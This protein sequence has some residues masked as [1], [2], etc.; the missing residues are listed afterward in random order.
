M[1]EVIDL[2]LVNPGTKRLIYQSLG[3]EVAAVEPPFWIAAIASSLRA[4]NFNVAIIDANA[5]N[6]SADETA[7]RIAQVRPRLVAVFVYGSQPSASTQNMTAAI[8]ICRRIKSI[9]DV[10]VGCGGLHPTALPERSLQETTADFIIEG[11]GG[12]TLAALIT[13]LKS[14]MNDYTAIPGLWYCEKG[15][16]QHTFTPDPSD[17]V[18]DVLPVAAWDLLPMHLYRAHN[19]HCFDDLNHRSPYAAIYTSLGCPF[20]CM[21]CCINALFGKPS[22]RYRSPRIVLDELQL[23]ATSYGV[24]NIKIIDE[25]F[26]LSEKHYLPII[27]GIIQRGLTFNI[28]AYARVDTVQPAHLPLLKKAGVNWLALGIESADASVRNGARKQMRVDDIAAVIDQIH[29]A[30]IHVIGNYIF[31]LPDDTVE[32]MQQTLDLAKRL[33]CEFANFYT[34]MAYPGSQLYQVALQ[35]NWALPPSWAAYSQHGYETL[36]LPTKHLTAAQVLAFRDDAFRN[37]YASERYQAMISRVFSPA[38]VEHMTEVARHTLRR[39]ILEK[40]NG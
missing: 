35:N 11:E 7:G 27:E 31:G 28:W 5:E 16:I 6:L 13:S 29:A 10:P 24:R 2:V 22:I 23:L 8:E 38:V 30:G 19:W 14:G 21:F 32:T 20:S 39:K 40:N 34:A 18:D 4:K 37:Y 26:I 1:T 33:N 17:I 12:A 25:L 3:S 15:G 36:P 9:C